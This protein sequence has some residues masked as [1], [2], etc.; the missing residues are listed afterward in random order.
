M[1]RSFLLL[2]VVCMMAPG[3]LVSNSLT[4]GTI[5]GTNFGC[6]VVNDMVYEGSNPPRPLTE[7][8][9]ADQRRFDEQMKQWNAQTN[10]IRTLLG[11]YESLG[12][13]VRSAGTENGTLSTD[14]KR[15]MYLFL[16]VM[17]TP[18]V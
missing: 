13:A 15:A 4:A 18:I 9:R 1:S 5:F 12:P 2:V 11:G 7:Q 16:F 6:V 14:A 17:L 3:F 8:E 10:A